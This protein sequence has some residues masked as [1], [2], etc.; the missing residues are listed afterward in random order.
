MAIFFKKNMAIDLRKM[1]IW[2]KIW[3]LGFRKNIAIWHKKYKIIDKNTAIQGYVCEESFTFIKFKSVKNCDLVVRLQL[4][5][6]LK[7]V[8]KE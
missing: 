6:N 1:W 5:R 7:D 3:L 8:N 4:T 2:K